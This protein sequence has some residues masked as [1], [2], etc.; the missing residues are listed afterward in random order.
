MVEYSW[1]KFFVC[2]ISK[3]YHYLKNEMY[4]FD[5]DT[6]CSYYPPFQRLQHQHQHQ[7]NSPVVIWFGCC[8][9]LVEGVCRSNWLPASCWEWCMPSRTRDSSS[10]F[11]SLRVSRTQVK[12]YYLGFFLW[13]SQVG[14]PTKDLFI[15]LLR[16]PSV[17][18]LLKQ[19]QEKRPTLFDLQ[20]APRL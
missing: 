18:S 3:R 15:I 4:D 5:I 14:F 13:G 7:H 20:L 19:S 6:S 10:L 12:N 11:L 8:K 17:T 16:L 1:T 2:K 9:Q